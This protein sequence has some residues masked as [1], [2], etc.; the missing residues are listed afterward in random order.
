MSMRA[1]GADIRYMIGSA[2]Q[3]ATA[4]SH[5]IAMGE[6]LDVALPA[7]PNIAVIRAGATS[8]TLELTELI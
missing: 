3:T 8:G 5:L 1:V 2:S 7:T 4:T 6:R